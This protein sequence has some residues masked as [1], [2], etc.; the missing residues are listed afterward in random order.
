[1]GLKW[2]AKTEF[3]IAHV[4]IICTPG[5]F[6]LNYSYMYTWQPETRHTSTDF[7]YVPY[8]ILSHQ[9]GKTD[10]FIRK[11]KQRTG[12]YNPFDPWTCY[13]DPADPFDKVNYSSVSNVYEGIIFN[14]INKYFEPYFSSFLTNFRKNHNT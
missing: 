1:M 10:Q 4:S 5:Y 9:A 8:K 13:Y 7:I 6:V 3:V 12:R 2:S 14:Q 11:P